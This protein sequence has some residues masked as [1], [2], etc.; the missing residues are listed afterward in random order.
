MME[1]EI[2]KSGIAFQNKKAFRIGH[3]QVMPFE[4]SDLHRI[5]E[6]TPAPEDT[7]TKV[8]RVSPEADAA[9]KEFVKDC[10]RHTE[11]EAAQL[12]RVMVEH[13]PRIDLDDSRILY[14][15][16]NAIDRALGCD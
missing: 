2:N 4:G 12:L 8:L 3:M 11:M 7:S 9:E 13:D 15:A 1:E 6:E 16:I 5:R 14:D 10:W